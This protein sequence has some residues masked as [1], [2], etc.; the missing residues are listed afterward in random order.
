[1]S[2]ADDMAFQDDI[3]ALCED[4]LQEDYVDRADAFEIVPNQRVFGC[5]LAEKFLIKEDGSFE[6]CEL[7]P[8]SPVNIKGIE[9]GESFFR[10]L[11]KNLGELICSARV[12][13][14]RPCSD[15]DLRYFCGGKCRKDNVDDCGDPN[16]CSCDATYREDWYRR[17]VRINPYILEPLTDRME[18]R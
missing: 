11:T 2:K 5:G 7:C 1:M 12:E 18:R 4:Q 6:L 15:C 10:D 9:D 14:L 3:V 13:K 17:L 8:D 16:V